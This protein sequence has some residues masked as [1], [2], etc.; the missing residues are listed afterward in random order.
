M[1]LLMAIRAIDTI[2]AAKNAS[3]AAYPSTSYRYL[4]ILLHNE[5]SLADVGPISFLLGLV[6]IH[7]KVD[8]MLLQKSLPQS[9]G[10]KL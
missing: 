5:L 3:T 7:I 1:R 4:A 10:F 8:D 2:L 6:E 9:G